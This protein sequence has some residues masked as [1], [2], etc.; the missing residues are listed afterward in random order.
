MFGY[1]YGEI[2]GFPGGS[3]IKNP[4]ASAGDTS[5]IPG[6]GKSPGEG[7]GNPFQYPQLENPIPHGLLQEKK[8]KSIPPLDFAQR[9]NFA[10]FSVH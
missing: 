7:N 1:A 5:S 10:L 3:E 9:P 2:L 6:S 8:K 4:P